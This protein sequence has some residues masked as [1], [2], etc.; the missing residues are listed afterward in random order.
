MAPSPLPQAHI[1]K[2]CPAFRGCG[3]TTAS[4]SP[5][6][7]ATGC[8]LPT[9]FP[10]VVLNACPLA[11]TMHWCLGTWTCSSAGICRSLT[12]IPTPTCSPKPCP[13]SPPVSVI[14]LSLK[15]FIYSLCAVVKGTV[16][17]SLSLPSRGRTLK[18]D[19]KLDSFYSLCQVRSH[20]PPSLHCG[21]SA[22]EAAFLRLSPQLN[23]LLD[24]PIA[25]PHGDWRAGGR[26]KADFFFHLGGISSRVC[27]SLGSSS[28]PTGSSP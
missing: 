16:L 22:L 26:E 1:S 17:L 24:S 21:D 13:L 28:L 25:G 12:P 19:S 15:V 7:A 3:L 23:W 9:D 27:L 11:Y 10:L 18:A 20:S 4:S 14:L 2:L 8:H 6:V 5:S